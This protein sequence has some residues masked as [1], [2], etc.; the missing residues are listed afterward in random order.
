ML[1]IHIIWITLNVIVNVVQ[2]AFESD[3]FCIYYIFDLLRQLTFPIILFF[4]LK[5]D[6]EYW[7]EIMNEI[8]S[9]NH[10]RLSIWDECVEYTL[11]SDVNNKHS[12]D[13]SKTNLAFDEVI[14]LAEMQIPIFDW[15]CLGINDEDDNA[16]NDS[17]L[18]MGTSATVL[19][20]KYKGI[21]FIKNIICFNQ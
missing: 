21:V 9:S 7:S 1:T 18:G 14:N 3:N 12:S 11:N 13:A 4:T 17:Y 16:M 10:A 20:G 8:M 5:S 2:S 19:L 6:S 15:R